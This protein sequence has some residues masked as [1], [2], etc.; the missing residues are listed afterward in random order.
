MNTGSP[1]RIVA[2]SHTVES[3]APAETAGLGEQVG[4]ALRPGDVLLLRGDLGAGKTQ[5]ARGVA[6]GLGVLGPI[7]SPTFTLVNEYAGR[8][9]AGAAVPLAHIDLYRLGEG[10]DLDSVG[11]DDYFDGDWVVLIEWP[12]RAVDDGF[13]PESYLDIAIAD[14]GAEARTLIFI[15][16]GDAARL[17]DALEWVA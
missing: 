15:G 6:A 17:L 3:H 10:G 4:R 11:L 16:F 14:A 2:S 12:E 7:P 5:F 13:V 1:T 8:N 9:A